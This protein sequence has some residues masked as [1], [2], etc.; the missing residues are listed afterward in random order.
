MP[1][2]E[3]T[4]Q[5]VNAPKEGKRNGSIKSSEGDYYYAPPALLKLFNRG[6]VC[7][8]AWDT[9]ES[10]KWKRIQKK[11]SSL[12]VPIANA[13]STSVGR[14]EWRPMAHPVD[15]EQM[16]VGQCLRER[17]LMKVPG[18]ID[19]TELIAEINIFRDAWRNTFGGSQ[20]Q[21]DPE[22]DDEIPD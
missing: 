19:T 15:Q 3:I 9:D 12:P 17:P 11:V 20:K 21:R 13:K 18:L 5:Y 10:G 6:E 4:V 8:I 16:F 14:G 22:M 1:E 7:T 2:T